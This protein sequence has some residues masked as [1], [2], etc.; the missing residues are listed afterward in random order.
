MNL[1]IA[2][3]KEALLSFFPNR[4][5]YEAMM[6]YDFKIGLPR[7]NL[8]QLCFSPLAAWTLFVL[9]G[10]VYIDPTKYFFSLQKALGPES[11][12]STF[13]LSGQVSIMMGSFF[14]FYFLEWILRKEYLLVVLVFYFLAK[15]D[16]HIHLATSAILGIY[17]SKSCYLW[18][19]HVDLES[20]SRKIWKAVTNLLLLNWLI[21]SIITLLS[22]DYLQANHFFSGSMAQNRFE[23]LLLV[24]F[25]MYLGVFLLLSLWGHFFARRKIEP[26]LLPIYYSTEK[27]IL[28]FKMSAYLKRLLKVRIDAVLPEHL[29]SSEKFAEIKDQ[30]PGLSLSYLVTTLKKEISYLQEASSRLTIE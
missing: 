14:V 11:Y 15:S 4:S 27:W 28:R 21:I 17:F 30:S 25:A 10:L 3:V 24:I 20:E 8:M 6:K 12:M 26:S 18:W 19:F 29:K 13:L 2:A 22:L 23:F 1:I 7:Q 9:L 16:I 5:Y